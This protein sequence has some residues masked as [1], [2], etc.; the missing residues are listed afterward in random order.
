MIPF[1]G[2]WFPDGE[3]QLP[4]AMDKQHNPQLDHRGVQRPTWQY[5]KYAAAVA[6]LPLE[7]RRVALDVGAHVGLFAYWMQRDFDHV[8]CVEP[9]PDAVACL[10]LNLRDDRPHTIYLGAAGAQRGEGQL[11]IEPGMSGSAQL[12]I[13]CG[14]PVTPIDDLLLPPIDFLKIDVEGSELPALMGGQA[15][16]QRSRPVILIERLPNVPTAQAAID[17]LIAWGAT[18][19]TTLGND[20][21]LSWL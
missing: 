13:G 17:L 18:V 3:V 15:L 6:L 10:Q 7:R 2:W 14:T 5:S 16:I 11:V 4:R 9:N 20:V 8:I 19:R 12:T 1:D 21:I